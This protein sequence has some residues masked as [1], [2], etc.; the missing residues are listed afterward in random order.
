MARFVLVLL[1]LGVIAW[2]L[3]AMSRSW[4]RRID[5]GANIPALLPAPSELAEDALHVDHATYLG[6]V[7]D[8]HWLDRVAAQGLGHRGPTAL[9]V[10]S[11]G[12]VLQRVGTDAL[13]IP[14]EVI[15]HVELARGL[16]GRV[17]G[18]DGVIVVSWTWGEQL[19]HTGVRI[20]DEQARAAVISALAQLPSGHLW[21]GHNRSQTPG[22]EG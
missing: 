13:F 19:L 21:S 15:T 9:S 8:D 22:G 14:Q 10:D 2:A 5:S 12:V 3:M 1:V 20:P 11:P 18:R 17:Y 6:T 16:A 4:R 7:T